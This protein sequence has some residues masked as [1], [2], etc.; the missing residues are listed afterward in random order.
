[1]DQFVVRIIRYKSTKSLAAFAAFALLILAQNAAIPAPAGQDT[2]PHDVSAGTSATAPAA[3][4]GAD[5][6][7]KAKKSAAPPPKKDAGDEDEKPI[8][9][10][11]VPGDI[12]TNRS[13]NQQV[14]ERVDRIV[15]KHFYN[16]D[17]V[18]SA[19]VPALEHNRE[20]ILASKNLV[21]LF[22]SINSTLAA[23]KCSH[24]EFATSNDEIFYFLHDL[25]GR[26]NPK[27]TVSGD[28]VGFMS[29]PP[30]FA[31]DRVR[32]VVD[33]SPAATAGLQVGDRIIS[34]DSKPYLGQS[35]FFGLSGKKVSIE[36]ER[37][38]KKAKCIIVPI[39]KD[40][41][42]QYVD[43]IRKSA[44]TFQ[45]GG[46]TVGYVHDWCGGNDAHAALDEVLEGKLCS[47]DGLILDLRDGYGGNSLEDLDRFFRNP[48]GYPQFILTDR[49]GHAQVS[50]MTYDKPVVALI[51]D[52]A[53]SGKELL[54][55]S[56]KTSGRAPLVGVTTAG[57]VLAGKLF[58]LDKRTALYLAVADGTVGGVRLEGVGVKPDIEI[59]D[60]CSEAGKQAQLQAAEDRL[61]LM[62]QK[63]KKS[64]NAPTS[65]DADAD[66]LLEWSRKHRPA[67]P[68]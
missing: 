41:Y 42:M 39:K 10:N 58:P 15:R 56:L 68:Q 51:N 44:R 52:G 14:L 34:V 23:L 59:G 12:K 47:T 21:E 43:G 27:L 13:Y 54:A 8:P 26:W 66:F 4:G 25:F 67:S 65:P 50:T 30:R 1:M 62:L 22:N 16:Y 55:Y 64:Y 24:T 49:K 5:S 19:W 6:H 35:N 37:A 9:Q 40:E 46:H 31:V 57:A 7:L 32:Y 2:T 63:P 29:G 3:T 18:T 33:G 20:K 61:L 36:Y 28:F 45:L 17:L 48:A 53:R 38:G 60:N 11:W